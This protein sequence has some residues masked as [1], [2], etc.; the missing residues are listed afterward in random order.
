MKGGTTESSRLVDRDKSKHSLDNGRSRTF[1]ML[2]AL[3]TVQSADVRPRLDDSSHLDSCQDQKQ[4]DRHPGVAQWHPS[5]VSRPGVGVSPPSPPV[6]LC[7]VGKV[8]D[9]G[10][11]AVLYT[12]AAAADIGADTRCPI[13]WQ[14]TCLLVA[15]SRSAAPCTPVRRSSAVGHRMGSGEWWRGAFLSADF[16]RVASTLRSAL[17][18]RIRWQSVNARIASE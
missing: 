16:P 7:R 3:K 1:F 2:P 15:P 9:L 5:H 6:P 10:W 8:C 17:I 12:P 4:A 13:W 14:R 11:A 18:W